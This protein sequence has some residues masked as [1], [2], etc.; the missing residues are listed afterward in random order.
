MKEYIPQIRVLSV[1]HDRTITAMQRLRHSLDRHKLNHYPV[2]EVF[3][4]LEAGRCGIPSGIVAIEVEG[5][6]VWRGKELTE[7]LADSFASGLPSFVE[8]YK[9]DMGL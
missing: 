2:R 9:Q 7:K 5:I 1:D 4:H 3:C 6:I 8:K